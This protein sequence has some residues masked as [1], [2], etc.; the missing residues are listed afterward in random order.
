[1]QNYKEVCGNEQELW[2]EVQDNE[3]NSFLQ[4]AKALGCVWINGKE[5]DP[6]E[7]NNSQSFFHAIFFYAI[8]DNGKLARIPAFA[9]FE[10]NG[11]FDSVKRYMFC[12]FI[13]GKLISPKEYWQTHKWLK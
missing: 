12:E 7:Q 11:Q 2:F 8:T 1:M 9:W 10:K 13:Q 4:W 3:R 6:N 5:I